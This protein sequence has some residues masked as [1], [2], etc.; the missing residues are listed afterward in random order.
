VRWSCDLKEQIIILELRVCN[1]LD[2]KV[3][4]AKTLGFTVSGR[5]P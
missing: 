3:F 2:G 5:P 4:R 1:K